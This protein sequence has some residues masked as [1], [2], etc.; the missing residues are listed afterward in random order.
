MHKYF[1][2]VATDLKLDSI[3]LDPC[4]PNPCYNNGTCLSSDSEDCLVSSNAIN[5]CCLCREGFTGQQ[6]DKGEANLAAAHA[7]P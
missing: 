2:R 7:F 4:L 6:C 5:F 1:Y 3:A